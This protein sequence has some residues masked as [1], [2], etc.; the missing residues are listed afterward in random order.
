M[1]KN[2]QIYILVLTALAV[3][4][5][6]F[7]ASFIACGQNPGHSCTAITDISSSTF[8]SS[9][10]GIKAAGVYQGSKWLETPTYITGEVGS[11]FFTIDSSSNEGLVTYGADRPDLMT[12]ATA[13]VP[14]DLRASTLLTGGAISLPGWYT[15]GYSK[16]MLIAYAYFDV[17]FTHNGSE[18][19]IKFVYATN[20][21]HPDQRKGDVLI[22]DNDGI[23]KWLDEDSNTLVAT[24]PANPRIID[25]VATLSSE[26][27]AETQYYFPLAAR[28]SQPSA[29]VDLS[30]STI[31]N[32]GL[33]FYVDFAYENA[34]SFDPNLAG[35]DISNQSEFDALSKIE[36]VKSA[37]LIQNSMDWGAIL[38]T[39]EG[40]VTCQVTLEIN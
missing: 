39:T 4:V 28:V 24:R 13:L 18:E 10:S 1:N 16:V 9:S 15:G 2:K 32:K 38:T 11:V 14:F 21:Y 12:N 35:T 25:L 5:L 27:H 8:S 31:K 20:D 33:R 37:D 34:L 40:V 7:C 26:A 30:L 19:T 17:F 29:G 36:L 23:F 3:L 6:V 22:K